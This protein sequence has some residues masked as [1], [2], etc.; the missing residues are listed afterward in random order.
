MTKE[1]AKAAFGKR[2]E[3]KVRLE[4]RFETGHYHKQWSP[5][6]TPIKGVLAGVRDYRNGHVLDADFL[7]CFIMEDCFLV[8]LIVPNWRRN[9]IPVPLEKCELELNVVL[10]GIKISNKDKCCCNCR[11]DDCSDKHY[12]HQ[13]QKF[14]CSDWI[15]RY[16][17]MGVMNDG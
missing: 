5:V 17:I 11:G 12:N 10:N 2:V 6:E 1:E 13:D 9:P 16:K 15:D 3:S 8:A 14:R 7:R 4:K